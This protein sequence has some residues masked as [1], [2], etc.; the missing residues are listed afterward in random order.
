MAGE[1]PKLVLTAHSR[2]SLQERG[3]EERWVVKTLDNP[4]W[5]EPDPRPDCVRAFR[6]ISEQNNRILRAVYV[7]TPQEIRVITAFFDRD[8]KRP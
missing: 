6:T 8:A 5:K 1:K 7:E 4:D 3:I 2:T